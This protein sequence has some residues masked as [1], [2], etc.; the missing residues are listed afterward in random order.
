MS[1]YMIASGEAEVWVKEK[2][3]W[4]NPKPKDPTSQVFS[5][6]T[7]KN[8]ESPVTPPNAP[9]QT[10]LKILR[11]TP[12]IHL[13]KIS[14]EPGLESDIQRASS[15]KSNSRTEDQLKPQPNKQPGSV[16]FGK[17]LSAV[18]S[19]KENSNTHPEPPSGIGASGSINSL[20]GILESQVKVK[21]QDGKA[22]SNLLDRSH[23]TA[24]KPE[25]ELSGKSAVVAVQQS[26]VTVSIPQRLKQLDQEKEE[27]SVPKPRPKPLK[28]FIPKNI[29]NIVGNP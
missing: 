27:P 29:T 18:P 9:Q 21:P 14:E 24:V 23:P 17:S 26:P 3:K 19:V 5:D 20:E 12:S 7:P 13:E 6:S 10:S 8:Q 4:E 1:F 2:K 28:I 11:N 25:S 15:G 22:Y 16:M